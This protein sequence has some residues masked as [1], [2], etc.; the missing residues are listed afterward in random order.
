MKRREVLLNKRISTERTWSGHAT[1]G[2]CVCE[3]LQQCSFDE[4]RFWV[5]VARPVN[6][7]FALKARLLNYYGPT[8]LARNL[9]CCL[10]LEFIG[11]L[12]MSNPRLSPRGTLRFPIPLF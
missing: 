8:E 1:K 3:L 9:S 6:D 4:G 11:F 10:C 12:S 2:S 5:P 7:G